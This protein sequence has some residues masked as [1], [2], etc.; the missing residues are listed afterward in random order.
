MPGG[1]LTE[2]GTIIDYRVDYDKL[3]D[4]IVIYYSDWSYL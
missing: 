4:T 1:S 3:V 2:D